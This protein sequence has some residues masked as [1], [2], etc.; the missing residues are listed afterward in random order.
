MRIAVITGSRADFG[1]LYP[2]LQEM[3]QAKMEC[4]L[5]VTGQ[6]LLPEFGR[7][8]NEIRKL[9]I[10]NV[11]EVDVVGKTFSD[12]NIPVYFGKTVEK[13]ADVFRSGYDLVL[14]LGDRWE[15]LAAASAAFYSHIPVA[16]MHGGDVSGE[17]HMDAQA[18]HVISRLA[19]IHFPATK[20]SAERL[21]RMGEEKWRIFPVG[22]T[23]IDYIAEFLAK[24]KTEKS[25]P[26]LILLVQHPLSEETGKAENQISQ[27]LEAII[28]LQKEMPLHVVA[29]YPDLDPGAESVMR[30]LQ[31]YSQYPFIRI[32]KNL[33][34]DSFLELMSRASV[35][36]GNSSAA[37]IE[38]PS[39]RLPA[40]NIGTRQKGREKATN[41]IGARYDKGK[42]KAAI[43]KALSPSF[44]RKMENIRNPY[45]HGK[46]SGK[47][48][49]IIASL[50]QNRRLLRKKL[51]SL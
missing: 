13:L 12:K 20:R 4:D 1:Y 26:P 51:V 29:V 3:E 16:H 31:K 41:V 47:I 48:V 6:H 34:R 33:S 28:E 7:S 18:R 23:S 15:T 21:E 42:I 24:A 30:G 10:K 36:V 25:E 9:G 8:A 49:T 46:A 2:V 19:H 35:M 22:S 43:K 27:T 38:A 5:V 50:N 32:K 39:F 44:Q 40:V 14:L 45:G 37:I 17:E 11:I